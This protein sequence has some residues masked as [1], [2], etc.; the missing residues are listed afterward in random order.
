MVDATSE[1]EYYEM[2]LEYCK[3]IVNAETEEEVESIKE[4]F[5][6]TLKTQGYDDITV[7][8]FLTNLNNSV[9]AVE[10]GKS[11][12]ADYES[13]LDSFHNETETLQEVPVNTQQ[14]MMVGSGVGIGLGILAGC[15]ALRK[16]TLKNKNVK[17]L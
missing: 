9:E 4:E 2:I 10:S 14:T 5:A 7:D 3:A 17:N 1:N 15:F 8:Q 12:V 6:E 13:Q 16:K 11:S